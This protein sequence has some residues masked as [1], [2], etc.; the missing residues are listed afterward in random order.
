MLASP[1]AISP[2]SLVL[3]HEFSPH[4]SLTHPLTHSL[5]HSPTHPLTHSPTHPFTCSRTR[6]LPRCVRLWAL[7]GVFAGCNFRGTIYMCVC[8]SCGV[9][10]CCGVCM[11]MCVCVLCCGVR[12]LSPLQCVHERLLMTQLSLFSVSMNDY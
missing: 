1:R 3:E 2:L 6:L 9:C 4:A 11:C 5:T 7:C 8:V 10:L 12:L